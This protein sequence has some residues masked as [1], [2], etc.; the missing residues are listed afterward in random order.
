[1]EGGLLCIWRLFVGEVGGGWG[2]V[3]TGY[4]SF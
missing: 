2:K 1:M 4:H 3:V